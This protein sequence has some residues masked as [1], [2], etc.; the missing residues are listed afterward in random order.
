MKPGGAAV[1]VT[2]EYTK[3]EAEA[4]GPDNFSFIAGRGNREASDVSLPSE[5]NVSLVG[6][7]ASDFTLKSLDGTSVHLAE[8][9]GKIVLLDF[10]ATWCPP[11]RRE[12]PTIEALSRKYKDQGV[13]VYGVNNEDAK[14]AKTFL[15]QHHPDLAT[16]HDEKGK[17]S[18]VYGCYSI[19]TVMVIDRTGTV[20]AHFIGERQE[21]ELVAALKQAGMQ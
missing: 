3:I 14:T 9:Q 11:C 12:L 16:L 13:L 19:P 20:V 17:V 4:P 18:R 1:E 21:S 2:T 15:A 10:W 5:R 7:R 6:T 8:L